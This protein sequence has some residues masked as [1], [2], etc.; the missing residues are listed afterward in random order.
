M[1]G[2]SLDCKCNCRVLKQHL[3]FSYRHKGANSG[4]PEEI[5]RHEARTPVG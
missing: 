5:S 3:L 4:G 2:E 1:R